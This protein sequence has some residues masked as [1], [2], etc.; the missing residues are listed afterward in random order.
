MSSELFEI[1]LPNPPL[2]VVVADL[3]V[4]QPSASDTV[5]F[6]VATGFAWCPLLREVAFDIFDIFSGNLLRATMGKESLLFEFGA[7]G[8]ELWVARAVSAIPGRVLPAEIGRSGSLVLKFGG[9]LLGKSGTS[10]GCT[11]T[12]SR[13]LGE[14]GRD[15]GAEFRPLVVGVRPMDV[16]LLATGIRRR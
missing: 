3:A 8:S 4:L 15:E 7:T 6:G 12:R 5:G 16:K 10:S 13:G 9:V 11:G 2:S 14:L 1:V